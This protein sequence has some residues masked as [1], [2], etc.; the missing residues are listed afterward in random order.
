[1]RNPFDRLVSAWKHLKTTRDRLL[2]EVLVDPPREG[3][4][5]RHF[6]RPQA[7][8]LRDAQTGS[9]VV[10]DIMR[11][12]SL[13][14]DY[15]RICKRIGKPYC[16]LASSNATRRD[17]YWRPYFTSATRSMAETLFHEDLELFGYEF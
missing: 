11:F 7:A 13:Q 15:N 9:F 2:E 14:E 12:E 6:T 8:I 10:D 4:D 17:R 16:S 1:M 5:Y 3:H